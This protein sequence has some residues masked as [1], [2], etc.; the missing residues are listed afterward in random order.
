[1]RIR[2]CPRHRALFRRFNWK[3]VVRSNRNRYSEPSSIF[4]AANI[5]QRT[6]F[7]FFYAWRL[8]EYAGTKNMFNWNKLAQLSVFPPLDNSKLN[9]I[10]LLSDLF[11]VCIQNATKFAF[12]ILL[13]I[14]FVSFQL[15]EKHFWKV[16]FWLRY[17]H[18][19]HT[20]TWIYR[21]LIPLF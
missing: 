20:Y 11:F 15:F 1:M 13:F 19:T 9:L 2:T 14:L 21:I 10:H 12:C 4:N 16:T 17:E 7:S 5:E 8:T 6:N 3:A 18:S